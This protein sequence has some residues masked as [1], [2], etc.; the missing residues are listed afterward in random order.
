MKRKKLEEIPEGFRELLNDEIVEKTDFLWAGNAGWI[1]ADFLDAES[2][3][4]TFVCA[5]RETGGHICSKCGKP[6][7]KNRLELKNTSNK[8]LQVL[9]A[10]CCHLWDEFCVWKKSLT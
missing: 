2:K 8:I 9:C 10:D 1:K 6:A 3:A 4:G 5:I 7:D